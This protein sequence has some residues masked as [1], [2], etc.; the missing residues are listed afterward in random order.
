[1]KT[2][3]APASLLVAPLVTS[4]ARPARSCA[5][6]AE[7]V[8][9]VAEVGMGRR[10]PSLV[11]RAD[12]VVQELRRHG[13]QREAAI[14]AL[15]AARVSVRRG[16]LDDARARIDRVRVTEDSPVATRL[17]WREVRSELAQ[18]RGDR[19]H[20]RDHVR[21]GLADLHA[22]QS[23]FG[24]LDLQSTLVG[25]GRALALQGLRL[26]LAEGSPALAYEWSERARALVGRVTPVRPPADEQQAADCSPSCGCCTPPIPRLALQTAA[27]STSCAT[28]SVSRAGTATEAARSASPRP[29]RRCRPSWPPPT[30]AS[31][32]TSRS[33]GGSPRS[34]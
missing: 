27:V 19:R 32:R 21:A 26:A 22:W 12:A 2:P 31:W 29:S 17:L 9:V 33:T 34:S 11:G 1:M 13:H 7:A 20:A 15:Q 6:R 23:S 14:V 30:P 16:L 5:T 18:A 4:A 10:G 8:E 3:S 28:G 24:S 25:H